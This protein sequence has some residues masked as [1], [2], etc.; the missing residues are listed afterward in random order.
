MLSQ[1]KAILIRSGETQIWN[2]FSGSTVRDLGCS[3]IF[4]AGKTLR[5]L[6]SYKQNLISGYYVIQN[7]LNPQNYHLV[8]G[9]YKLSKL[10]P[11]F[12]GM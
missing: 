8:K 3:I 1:R 9:K 6:R 2:Q 5:D 4:P 12:W 7:F 11:T 10:V